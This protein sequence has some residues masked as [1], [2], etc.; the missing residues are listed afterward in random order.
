[1]TAS[2]KN[3]NKPR[4]ILYNTEKKKTKPIL[5]F[6]RVTFTGRIAF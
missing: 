6:I 5:Y 3:Q 1:M 2:N 4:A